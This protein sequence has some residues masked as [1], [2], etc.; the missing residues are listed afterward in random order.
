[1]QRS[2]FDWGMIVQATGG[3]IK[4]AKSFW[5]LLS[6]KF[7]RGKPVLKSPSELPQTE[8]LIPQPNAAPVAIARKENS[9][10]AKTL[11]VWNNPINC[12]VVPLEKLKE[13][14]LDWVDRLR[15]RPL[16]RRDTRL[17]LTT[18]QYP[19]WSYGLSSLYASPTALDKT[20]GSIYRQALSPLGYNK[21]LPVAFRTLPRE[22]QGADLRL[23]SIEKLG[24]D[25]SI[26]LQH[27]GSN[28]TL[29]NSLQVV[30]ESF[31]ME[32]GLEG[33][34]FTRPY[35]KLQA[36]ASHS[37]FKILWQYCH[38]H[39]VKLCLDSRW[40]TPLLRVGDRALN[41]LFLEQSRPMEEMIAL[42]RLRKHLRLHSLA[43]ILMADGT[44][45]DKE[46]VMT[47]LQGES[48]R[49]FSWEQPTKSDY[50]IWRQAIRSITSNA[51]V[52]P[53]PLGD[54]THTPHRPFQ[55]TASEDE[56][57]V[58]VKHQNGTFDTYQRSVSIRPTRSGYKYH[59]ISTSSG[60][61]PQGLYASTINHS[62]TTLT[63]HSTCKPFQP[64]SH[65]QSFFRTLYSLSNATLWDNLEIDDGGDW[66]IHA[67]TNGTLVC[68][69]DGSYM[70]DLSKS[71]CSGAFILHCT[72]TKKEAKGCFVDESDD[73]SNYR[74]ELL[75]AIG[76]LLLILAAFRSNPT[77]SIPPSSTL[78]LYCDNKGVISHG[79]DPYSALKAEQKQANL[80]RLLK[81]YTRELPCKI[82]WLHVNGHADRFKAFN[83]LTLPEQLNVR[84]DAI[85]KAY[86]QEAIRAND[87]I[88]DIFPEERITIEIN[89]KKVR[90]SIRKELYK[91]WGEKSA[92]H[93][94]NRQGKVTSAA[95]NLIHWPSVGKA[96]STFPDTFQDWVTRHIL[97]FNGCNRYL[98]RW[99]KGVINVCS[100]CG[101]PNEDTKHITRCTNPIR[102][103][104]FQEGVTAISMW[105]KKNHTPT[106]LRQMITTYLRQRGNSSMVSLTPNSS[107]Y[108][109]FAKAQDDIGFDNLIVG[110]LPTA[111]LSVMTPILRLI[112]RRGTD[113]ESWAKG[114]SRE[115]LLFTHKQWLHRNNIAHYKPS[116]GK[117]VTEHER[118]DEQFRSLAE[119][120]LTDLPPQ[121]QHLL[122]P[123]TI[124]N[125]TSAS[126]TDKQFWIA[127]ITAA[128]TET[129]ILK[130]LAKRCNT[131]VH[132]NRIDSNA[133]G[134]I[135]TSLSSYQHTTSESHKQRIQTRS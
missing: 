8:L 131:N 58:Y 12:P 94:F 6:W 71:K 74:G 61:P 83:D 113:A 99:K 125:M 95:F 47:E 72:A 110:R 102:S 79:N 89:G 123:D 18:Q 87:Y 69:N 73:A 56:V 117:T 135:T 130:R 85:A 27:W 91:Q 122:L 3:A 23:W 24:K 86:L 104:L 45:V 70:P 28:S 98:S 134:N 100:S 15:S 17:S 133:V 41:E 38:H 33:N 105:L 116:E 34:I 22:Y 29:G 111:L 88:I 126:T 63:L 64:A 128:L 129:A 109:E 42:N 118:V 76:P 65:H 52:Y 46:K 92:K 7:N 81:T 121:H 114:L 68:C 67:I 50:N 4:P 43:D 20:M 14:G 35:T 51:L 37:W 9:H 107:P 132:N 30:Y 112:N 53:S 101:R 32:L 44:T 120:A 97:D 115:L 119:M 93:L 84:C 127:D 62:D 66:L 2:T 16:E 5:Y 82:L 19:K 77:V 78:E 21:N 25:I 10:T 13:K 36:L 39:Q 75:G 31:M 26:L 40:H 103:E 108:H 106:P 49:T 57:F 48:T 90:S 11:G 124:S 1:M 55:S 59:K 54:F 80:I 60:S 96:M